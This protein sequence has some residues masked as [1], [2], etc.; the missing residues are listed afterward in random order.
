MTFE[1]YIVEEISAGDKEAEHTPN[2]PLVSSVLAPA[3]PAEIPATW[4]WL[5]AE[6]LDDE[7]EPLRV[8]WP[9]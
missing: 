1:G 5:L 7:G 8:E 2:G 3:S 4:R 9:L 6:D